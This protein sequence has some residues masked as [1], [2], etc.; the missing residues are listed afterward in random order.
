M[1]ERLS[2][3]RPPIRFGGPLLEPLYA[4]VVA[5]RNRRFDR[6]W[7]ILDDASSTAAPVADHLGIRR[8]GRSA[9]LPI[10]VISVGNLS[11]GGTG[12]TPMVVHICGFLR[13]NGLRP[14]IATR[15]YTLRTTGA[16]GGGD[17]PDLYRRVLPGVP[18]VIGADRTGGLATFLER[19][20]EG[21][22]DPVDC[23][24]LDDGFQ[25]RRLW[26]D[27]DI[28]LVDASRDPFKDRLLPAGWLREPVQSLARASAVVLTHAELA[29]GT[30]LAVLAEWTR[31][32]HGKPAAAATRHLWTALRQAPQGFEA[33][34]N[35]Q[36][37]ADVTLPLDW[38][39]GRRVVAACAIGNPHGFLFALREVLTSDPRDPGQLAGELVLP[40]HDPYDEP[41]VERLIGTARAAHAAAIV[42]TDKDWSK[43][44]RVEPTRWPCPVVRPVLTLG[45]DFGADA[46]NDLVI[47]TARQPAP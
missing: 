3:R 43:L 19:V 2:T 12:K 9:R 14:C 41:T 34:E 24:V 21:V 7:A 15:G 4:A 20:R 23:V 38:L 40:D 16:R 33:S 36:P 22:A 26:R 45:F 30:A 1:S 35:A 27:L 31:R 47:R 8:V 37:P 17:E 6:E 29:D 28:V 11:V 18:L 5:R 32:M 13:E 44:R 25:H 39:L 42:V 10:P 46:L